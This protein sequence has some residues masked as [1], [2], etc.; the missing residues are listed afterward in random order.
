MSIR[1]I[2]VLGL[3]AAS[4]AGCDAATTIAGDAVRAETRN[5]VVAQCQEAAQGAG[6]VAGRIGSVC[7]CSADAFLAD[8]PFSMA[9]LDPARLEEIL[10]SCVAQTGPSAAD[11]TSAE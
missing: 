9:D 3:A 1:T 8:E 10:N 11:N 2:M 7:E 5:A 6:I 4:L